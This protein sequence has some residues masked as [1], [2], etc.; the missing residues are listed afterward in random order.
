M[1]FQEIEIMIQAVEQFI[2]DKKGA[3]VKINRA[4]IYTNQRQLMMLLDAYRVAS[5]DK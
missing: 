4:A 5:G 3:K 1:N 2:F